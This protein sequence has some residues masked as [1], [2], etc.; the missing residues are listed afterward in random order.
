MLLIASSY[1]LRTSEKKKN[2]L[3]IWVRRESEIKNR[4]V[5]SYRVQDEI[6]EKKEQKQSEAIHVLNITQWKFYLILY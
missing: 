6:N 1:S 3:D 5:K 2:I 4:L